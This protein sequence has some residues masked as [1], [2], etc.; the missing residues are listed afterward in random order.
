[1]SEPA[2]RLLERGDTREGMITLRPGQHRIPD[3]PRNEI[4]TLCL[5]RSALIDVVETWNGYEWERKLLL[6]TVRVRPRWT[7]RVL[8]R[9]AK[10]F[11]RRREPLPVARVVA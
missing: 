4:K 6:E 5:T 11:R 8:R 9:V 3:G 10:L 7:L 2:I 1:M